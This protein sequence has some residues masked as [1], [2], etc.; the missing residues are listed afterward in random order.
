MKSVA[1]ISEVLIIIGAVVALAV[2][3]YMFNTTRTE[4][5]VTLTDR[6]RTDCGNVSVQIEQAAMLGCEFGYHAAKSGS[7]LEEALT[8]VYELTVSGNTN[9]MQ[10]MIKEYKHATKKL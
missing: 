8:L 10:T 7:S 5:N 6:N 4:L 1:G 3:L 2:I 9:T